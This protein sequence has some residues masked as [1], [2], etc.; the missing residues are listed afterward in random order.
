M[1][2]S[3]LLLLLNLFLLIISGWSFLYLV[4]LVV[5]GHFWW[6][7]YIRIKNKSTYLYLA[8]W[9]PKILHS[10]LPLK[11]SIA[12]NA[13]KRQAQQIFL[14]SWVWLVVYNSKLKNIVWKKYVGSTMC[15]LQWF[16]FSVKSENRNKIALM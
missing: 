3:I 5:S 13:W 1:T 9:K 6:H 8:L 10:K 16:L 11:I 4:V 12:T 14:I 15:L 7:D 2:S